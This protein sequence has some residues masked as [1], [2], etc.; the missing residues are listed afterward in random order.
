[1][2]VVTG[3]GER[4]FSAGGD[5]ESLLPAAVDAQSDI[6]NPDP[7]E[8][9]FSAVFKPIVAAI[10]GVCIG[11]G[12]ELMLGTDIRVAAVDSTFGLGE[13]RWG[14]IPGAGSHVRL[15]H[16]VPWAIAMELLLLGRTISAERALAVGL[17]NEVRPS[18]EVTSRALEL[19]SEIAANAPVA[20][21]TAKE[22]AVQALRLEDAFALEHSL[23]SRVLAT[24]DAREGLSA[25]REKRP[26]I[27]D[28]R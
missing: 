24:N 23:N 6:V 8:R 17:V 28:G 11:G 19:A 7:R 12:L 27:Y 2:L 5:L 26:P 9:F 13:V 16:N 22:I 18:A 15:P 25:F 1:V 4:A 20:V 3:A 14:V 10:R 21:Q